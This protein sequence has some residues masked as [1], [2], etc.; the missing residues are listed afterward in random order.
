MSSREAP[1]D[2]EA[3]PEAASISFQCT[4][5]LQGN[6]TDTSVE[7]FPGLPGRSDSRNRNVIEVPDTSQVPDSDGQSLSQDLGGST[8]SMLSAD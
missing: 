1:P 5:Q 2:G 6:G 8:V 7:S 4:R 3:K